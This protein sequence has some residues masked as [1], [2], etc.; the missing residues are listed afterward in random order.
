MWR[1][2]SSREIIDSA[3]DYRALYGRSGSR[4]EDLKQEVPLQPLPSPP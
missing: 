4:A 1:K 3:L 2:H